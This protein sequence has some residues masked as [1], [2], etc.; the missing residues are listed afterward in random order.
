MKKTARVIV[1]YKCNRNC[2]GCCNTQPHDIKKINSIKEL[3][4]YEQVVITGG[5]PFL[6][7]SALWDLVRMLRKQNKKQELYIYTAC[8]SICEYKAILDK[9]DGVTV[10][11]HAEAN[12]DD[13]RSL[14][15][16]SEN[17]YDSVLDLRLFIDKRVYEKYDL[18]NIRLGTWDVVRKLEWK[19]DCKP[20]ENEDLLYLPIF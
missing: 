12:D 11:L 17:L 7:P 9:L 8:L 2:P 10:T 6:K 3:A 16:L 19:D 20:A 1:T 13:I 14:K 4:G 15:Y 5:E 18:S